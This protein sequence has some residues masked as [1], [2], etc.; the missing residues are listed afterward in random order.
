MSQQ[1]WQLRL[2]ISNRYVH[3]VATVLLSLY[4]KIFADRINMASLLKAGYSIE[5]LVYNCP[6]CSSN[7]E[8]LIS[9]VTDQVFNKFLIH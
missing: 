6:N 7:V 2:F 5:P 3:T 8:N 1:P 9:K 4:N